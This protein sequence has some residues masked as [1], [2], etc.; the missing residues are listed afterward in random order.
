MSDIPS[1]LRYAE[2]HEWIS[3]EEEG[4]VKVG[5]S[6]HAQGQLGDLVFVELPEE[7]ETFGRG[8]ACAVVESVKAAS[9][10]YCPVSGEIVVVNEALADTPEIVNN[11]PYGDGW[12]FSVKLDDPGELDE[13]MDAEAYREHLDES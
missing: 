12:L 2:S 8:D 3:Q 4:V 1:D 7:G 5:I 13:L 6:D 9:D 11:D 10:I